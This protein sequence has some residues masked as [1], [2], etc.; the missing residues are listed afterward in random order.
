MA[1]ATL[2]T[3]EEYRR[4]PC[5]PRWSELVRGQVLRLTPP[6]W[7]HGSVQSAMVQRLRQWAES[8][9]AG[10]VVTEVGFLLARGPDTVRA[11]D[12]AFVRKDRVPPPDHTG[13]FDGPPDLAIEVRSPGDR[14][15]RISDVVGD[16]LEAGT[17]EV[18][19]VDPRRRTI[20]V[21]RPDGSARIVHERD[22][23]ASP[24]VLPG[25]TAAVAE[26]LD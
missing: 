3:A 11:P 18:W 8:S 17:R 10:A 19:V 22:A 4:D 13:Y 16:Y 15:R 20:T 6:G 5:T 9:G 14:A 21:H 12:V 1:T 24:D 7:E 25:W 2:L 23:L 26:L